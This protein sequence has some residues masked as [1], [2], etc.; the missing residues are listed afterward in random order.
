MASDSIEREIL[1]QAPVA[2]VWTVVTEPEQ[3]AGWFS[4]A[5]ELDLRPGGEALFHWRDH[6]S[7]VEGRVE[8]VEPPHLFSFRWVVGAGGKLD[9]HNSTLVEFRLS[10]EGEGTRLT[11]V[12]SGFAALAVPEGERRR[13]YEDH[14]RGWDREVGDLSDYVGNR[15]GRR[16]QR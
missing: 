1:I 10:A 7:A 3:I 5:V 14:T 12:E 8:R 6:E 9:E 2:V 13:H 16:R 15:A 11:V 4:D